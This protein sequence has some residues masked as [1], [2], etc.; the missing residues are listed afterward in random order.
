MGLMIAP[1]LLPVRQIMEHCGIDTDPSND[2]VVV[3]DQV[4]AP[5]I[6]QDAY[7]AHGYENR[8]DYLVNLA[9]E[10]GLSYQAV[11]DLALTLGE[12]ED[13]DGLLA[14]LESA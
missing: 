8:E 9:D 1:P 2:D 7:N 3:E 10:Y 11:H 6:D 5:D 13:F 12:A 14:A 4:T